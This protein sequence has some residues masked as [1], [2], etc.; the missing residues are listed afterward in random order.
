MTIGEQYQEVS[1]TT[2]DHWC[3]C[4]CTFC[5]VYTILCFLKLFVNSGISLHI[6]LL[7]SYIFRFSFKI[8]NY[9]MGLVGNDEL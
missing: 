9:L 1:V 5:S 4:V 7:S 2:T 3:V 8:Y 6:M